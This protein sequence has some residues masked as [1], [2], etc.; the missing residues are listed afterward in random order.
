MRAVDSLVHQRIAA[1]RR[2]PDYGGADLSLLSPRRRMLRVGGLLDPERRWRCRVVQAVD[3]HFLPVLH[4]STGPV[5]GLIFTSTRLN[6]FTAAQCSPSSAVMVTRS[7]LM[8]EAPRVGQAGHANGGFR[9]LAGDVAQVNISERGHFA[10]A[11][12]ERRNSVVICIASPAIC[13]IVMSWMWTSSTIP[14]RPRAAFIRKHVL[15]RRVSA[16]P[17]A[18]AAIAIG[19][20]MSGGSQRLVH[21]CYYDGVET[22]IR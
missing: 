13:P 4:E 16:P 7:R 3:D 10:V 18:T 11:R 15:I 22:G 6:R 12:I 19:S 14:P 5:R 9:L 8:S 17:P 21:D 1:A 20:D 2:Y